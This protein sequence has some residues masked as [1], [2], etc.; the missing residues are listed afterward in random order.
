[1]TQPGFILN[2]YNGLSFRSFLFFSSFLSFFLSLLVLCTLFPIAIDFLLSVW[3]PFS[4]CVASFLS[5]SLRRFRSSVASQVQSIHIVDYIYRLRGLPISPQPFIP[6]P[7][8]LLLILSP[9]PSRQLSLSHT[10][11]ISPPDHFDVLFSSIT[12][13]T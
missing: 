5:P 8:P 3:F 9:D 4:G 2:S 13:S 12:S 7:P 6:P 10:F 1:M 11:F